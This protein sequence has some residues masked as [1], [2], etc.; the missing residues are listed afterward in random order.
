MKTLGPKV[1]LIQ[2][3]I[4]KANEWK[5]LL[6]FDM[7]E[8]EANKV[9]KFENKILFHDGDKQNYGPIRGTMTF[10]FAKIH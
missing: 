9:G 8:H 10:N 7:G 2:E 4:K 5:P 3:K 1:S 6:P